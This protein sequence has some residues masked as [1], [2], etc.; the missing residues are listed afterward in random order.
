MRELLR[1]RLGNWLHCVL[2]LGG[3]GGLLALLGWVLGGPD[4]VLWTAILGVIALLLSPR[5]TPGLIL[6][7]YGARP[8]S[9]WDVPELQQLLRVIAQRAGLP[10]PPALYY[11][12]SRVMNAFAVGHRSEAAIALSDG[13]LRGLGL[14]ELGG[15]LAHELSHIRNNDMWIMGLADA[16][17]RLTGGLALAGQIL[18]LVNLPLLLLGQATVPWLAVALLVAAPALSALLQL[19]LSRSR[20]YDA[21]LQAVR[22]TGDPRGLAAALTRLEQQHGGWIER[23]LLPG[24]RD[25]NPSVLRTHPATAERVRRLLALE[26]ELEAEPPLGL[27]ESFSL[28]DFPPI[29][30]RPRWR[31]GGSWY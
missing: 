3:M 4:G 19:A 30:R 31:F 21:D 14:R 1:H 13:I 20:E 24:R 22:L 6:R 26:R 12:P 25:P 15:V 11:V 28:R 5:L 29:T 18:L 2:L 17:S 16:V 10:R 7:M 9:G 23:I 8:L 27:Q